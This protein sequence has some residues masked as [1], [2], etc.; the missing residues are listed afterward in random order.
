MGQ[1]TPT[2]GAAG[3]RPAKGWRRSTRGWYVPEDAPD[4]VEQRILDQAGRLVTGQAVTGW[5]A[6]RLYGA[7]FCDGL[8]SDGRQVLPVPLVIGP[9]GKTRQSTGARVLHDRLP[10]HDIQLCCGVPVTTPQRATFDAMRLSP[11][12]WSAVAMLDTAVGAGIVGLGDMEQWIAGRAGWKGVRRARLAIPLGRHGVRSPRETWLRLFAELEL[13]LPRLL[14]NH[15]IHA[16]GGRRIGE[17][18]LLDATCGLVLEF[19][20]ADHRSAEQQAY[21][22]AKQ[23]AL[24]EL[25]LE[26]ARFTGR[27]LHDRALV[28]ARITA[29]RAEAQRRH[30]GTWTAVPPPRPV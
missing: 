4:L 14:V 23:D 10:D 21:D 20:G 5:A 8:A 25:G 2:P 6:L 18:D 27:D 13:G 22:L 17:V 9:R 3:A 1:V 7:G 11:G 15:V 26:V 12:L 29:R 19:D 28:R 16:P 30:P 24:Q